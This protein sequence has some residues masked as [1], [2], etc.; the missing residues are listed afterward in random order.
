M[1][2]SYKTVVKEYAT[3]RFVE[4][5]SEFIAHV[6]RIEDEEQAKAFVESIRKKHADATHNCFA[7]I[8]KGSEIAR[9]SDDGEPSGTAGMPIL[10]VIKREG[11]S[12]VCVVVT[13]YFG[14]ILLGAGG[15]VRA[16]AKGA[17][18]GLD[19]AGMAEFVPYLCGKVTVDYA[20]YEKIAKEAVK[21]AVTLTDTAFAADVTM[22]VTAKEDNFYRFAAFVTEYTGGKRSCS[23]TGNTFGP[24]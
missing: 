7:Y 3:D 20:D 11:L 17:K 13:R 19:A 12:G 24:A 22:T 23:V 18:M 1:S 5:K 8:L 2:G 21:Y 10:E 4:K 15:L 9:F 14:G 16:Y 6:G